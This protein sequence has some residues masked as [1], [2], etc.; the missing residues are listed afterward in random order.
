MKV[1]IAG[2]RYF[3]DYKTLC[4]FCNRILQNKN[5]I[6]IVSGGA[7]GADSLGEKYAMENDLKI[8]RFPAAWTQYGKRAGIIRNTKMAKYAAVL[9]AFWDGKSKGTLNMVNLA[10]KEGLIVHIYYY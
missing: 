1:I 7:K 3:D 2:G 10:K 5:T 8:V 4:Q 6:E 9:I